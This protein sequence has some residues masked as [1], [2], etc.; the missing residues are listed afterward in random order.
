MKFHRLNCYFK[1]VWWIITIIVEQ[2][3][4]IWRPHWC[5]Q[6]SWT[7]LHVPHSMTMFRI[8]KY[9]RHNRVFKVWLECDNSFTFCAH[10]GT[11]VIS[12]RWE[13]LFPVHRPKVLALHKKRRPLLRVNIMRHQ[14][15]GGKLKKIIFFKNDFKSFLFDKNRKRSILTI[16]TFPYPRKLLVLSYGVKFT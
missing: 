3:S 16:C 2:L 11:W 9:S 10:V 13:I 8:T 6:L 15:F 7:D 4:Y 5:K 1:E 14:A 12:D